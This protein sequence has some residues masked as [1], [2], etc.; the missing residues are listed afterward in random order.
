[1]KEARPASYTKWTR[2]PSVAFWRS[3]VSPGRCHSSNV[4]SNIVGSGITQ[5]YA[6]VLLVYYKPN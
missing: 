3:A 4:E 1:M 2:E 5:R 6:K